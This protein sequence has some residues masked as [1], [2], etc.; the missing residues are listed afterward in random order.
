MIEAGF[1]KKLTRL[2]RMVRDWNNATD[3]ERN[4]FRRHQDS[5]PAHGTGLCGAVG[6]E[7]T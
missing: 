5:V 6:S 1:R 7:V 3:N 2:E 4:E